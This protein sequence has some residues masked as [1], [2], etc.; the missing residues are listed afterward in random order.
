MCVKVGRRTWN[1]GKLLSELQACF[2]FPTSAFQRALNTRQKK[3][4][5]PSQNFRISP[6][7]KSIN[8]F[9][10]QTPACMGVHECYLHP[11]S[12]LSLSLW[13]TA[14]SFSPERINKA[15]ISQLTMIAQRWET[16]HI[17]CQFNQPSLH[18]QLTLTP[19][20]SAIYLHRPTQAVEPSGLQLI[21][22][23]PGPWPVDH[24]KL[25]WQQWQ[26]PMSDLVHTELNWPW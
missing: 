1:T 9:Q 8:L 2:I 4:K 12:T 23:P 16:S 3:N 24:L 26:I 18:P 11:L 21:P 6:W 20:L 25:E 5:T 7:L 17:T 10:A 14:F 22:P 19:A 15:H 13:F